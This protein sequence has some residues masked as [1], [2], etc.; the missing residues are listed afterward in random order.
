[1]I[2]K[3]QK[4]LLILFL[5]S[6]MSFVSL[7]SWALEP[8][9]PN[10]NPDDSFYEISTVEHL[11]WLAQ[12]VNSGDM[13]TAFKARLMNDIQL[14][15]NIA[16]GNVV[17]RPIMEK[18]V[19]EGVELDLSAF[20]FIKD[21]FVDW[22]PIGSKDYWFEGEF[23][24]NHHT[25]SHI[26]Y[27]YNNLQS[28]Y[29][30]FGYVKYANIHD[31]TLEN[32]YFYGRNDVGAVAA[33]ALGE[34]TIER[35]VVNA[36][37]VLSSNTTGD[38][39]EPVGSGGIVG[40]LQEGCSV[41]NCLVRDVDKQVSTETTFGGICCNN[42]GE[43]TN[44]L[45]N[46]MICA[47]TAYICPNN[48]GTVSNCYFCIGHTVP[49]TMAGVTSVSR[50][51]LNNGRACYLLNGSTDGGVWQ[52]DLHTEVLASGS[53]LPIG[54][55][56]GTEQVYQYNSYIYYNKVDGEIPST[57]PRFY[58]SD[59]FGFE[60]TGPFSVNVVAHY[61]RD[62]SNDG[63]RWF[64]VYLPF[65]IN[66]LQSAQSLYMIQ[67]IEDAGDGQYVVRLHKVSEIPACTPGFVFHRDPNSYVAVGGY[68]TEN[69]PIA[70]STENNMQEFGQFIFTGGL[71][72]QT[73]TSDRLAQAN[74]YYLAND[75]I[76]R[77]KN[78]LT[79]PPFR[80]YIMERK[81]G[82]AAP[83]R[84]TMSIED[85]EAT[86]I[87]FLEEAQ[88]ATAHCTDLLGRPLSP[89]AKGLLIMNHKKLLSR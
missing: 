50:T 83:A 40:T 14:N 19:S 15:T 12:E 68:A 85:E 88:K 32:C 20:D 11:L 6:L 33:H 86:G 23:D 89:S 17:C 35:C 18:L 29:G 1:M 60:G 41:K 65:A 79:I 64:S 9:E 22:T 72:S 42:Q 62:A 51:D 36:S 77:A 76:Y 59:E 25:I 21:G 44:C 45:A 24:G 28:S 81:T 78:A 37:R 87:V 49:S 57:L 53:L 47:D 75:A 82:G 73:I 26:Y 38:N 2:M 74:Y 56:E 63:H 55:D 84:F 71:K 8:Q 4:S 16:Y 43:I 67:S 3:T 31:L 48:T 39:G 27:N 13:A 30:L 69:E 58:L 80:A 61:T 46:D 54:E 70:F 34:V 52:Q 10:Q 7:P 66:E 5:A